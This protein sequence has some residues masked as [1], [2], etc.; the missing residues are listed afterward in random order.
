MSPSWFIVV[1]QVVSFFVS[2]RNALANKIRNRVEWK[3]V[4]CDSYSCC[5]QSQLRW[6]KNFQ[7][8]TSGTSNTS[9][10]HTHRLQW[11]WNYCLGPTGVQSFLNLIPCVRCVA[12]DT[13]SL[14]FAEDNLWKNIFDFKK[15]WML[16]VNCSN[17]KTVSIGIQATCIE[18]LK[19]GFL[20]ASKFAHWTWTPPWPRHSKRPLHFRAYF[21]GVGDPWF[22]FWFFVPES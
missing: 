17:L 16:H 18:T 19:F 22:L 20:K 7:H 6:I 4:A 8:Q 9:N 12:W 15:C 21:F 2:D 10:M 11:I 14:D 13:F 5:S 1:S 3:N